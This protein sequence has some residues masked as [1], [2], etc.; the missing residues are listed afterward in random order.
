MYLPLLIHMYKVADNNLFLQENIGANF[1]LLLS[2]SAV[3]AV[4]N[5]QG[6]QQS[7]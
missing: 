6:S 5:E 2:C 1:N 4:F 3:S 7:D